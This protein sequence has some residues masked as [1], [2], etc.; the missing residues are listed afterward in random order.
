MTIIARDRNDAIKIYSRPNTKN[1]TAAF[2]CSDGSTIKLT[3]GTADVNE[4]LLWAQNKLPDLE[5]KVANKI[6]LRKITFRHVAQKYIEDL[7][8]AV[9]GGYGKAGYVNYIRVA[10]NQLIPY[11]NDT[12]I[13]EIDERSIKKFDKDQTERLQRIP[14][15][16]TLN[17]F[18]VVL[19][20]IFETAYDE[21]YITDRTNIPRFTIKNKGR[22]ENPRSAFTND[23]LDILL[24][25]LRS[26]PT[27]TNHWVSRY[28]RSLLYW[29]VDF[30]LLTGV[31][32]GVTPLSLRWNEVSDYTN[33]DEQYN[34]IHELVPE[35]RTVG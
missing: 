2:K 19:R 20:G 26:W 5:Y 11:F 13:A 7:Q 12:P 30:L 3:T 29:Y 10:K 27:K 21:R 31:R 33:N 18:Y 16:G 28:K 9:D 1:L 14:A 24:K 6:P 32:P 35:N 8:R 23:E 22:K 15:K 17:N 4:A 34:Q 25:F